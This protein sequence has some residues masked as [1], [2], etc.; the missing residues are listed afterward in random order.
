[1]F[2]VLFYIFIDICIFFRVWE[3][4]GAEIRR[5]LFVGYKLQKI[6]RIKRQKREKKSFGKAPGVD[7]LP[8]HWRVGYSLPRTKEDFVDK[9]IFAHPSLGLF[10][11]HAQRGLYL[12]KEDL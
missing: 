6:K 1:M 8:I 4:S 7:T 2:G 5:V 11:L 10:L 12:A 9:T 3:N